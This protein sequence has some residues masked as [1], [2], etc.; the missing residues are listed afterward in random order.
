MDFFV[1]EFINKEDENTID[2]VPSNWM[3]GE[4]LCYWPNVKPRD[5]PKMCI[6]MTQPTFNWDLLAVRKLTKKKGM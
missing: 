3:K 1:V 4:D 6:K 2:I 5:I